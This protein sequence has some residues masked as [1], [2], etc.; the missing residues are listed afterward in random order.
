MTLQS[1]SDSDKG[2]ARKEIESRIARLNWVSKAKSAALP[3]LAIGAG[4]G[5]IDPIAF[6]AVTAFI[7]LFFVAADFFS[8]KEKEIIGQELKDFEARSDISNLEIESLTSSAN[9]VTV[10]GPSL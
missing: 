6:V 2:R 10:N 5:L 4:V 9:N 7:G 3:G 8:R 1:T